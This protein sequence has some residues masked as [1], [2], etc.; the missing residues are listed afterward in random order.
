[1]KKETFLDLLPQNFRHEKSFLIQ[2][3]LTDFKK[4]SKLK[5]YELN[6]IQKSS[7]LCTLNNLRK[8]RAIAIFKNELSISPNEAQLLLHCGISSVKSLSKLNP[9]ELKQRIGRL[10]RILRAKSGTNITLFTLK[11]WILKSNQICKS[12]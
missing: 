1:M 12:L 7:S 10:E 5:D 8:I 4:L 11:Y 9:Y 2:N 6:N 3:K